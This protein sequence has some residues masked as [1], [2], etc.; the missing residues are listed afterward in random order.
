M[1]RLLLPI[2]I[3][4]ASACTGSGYV[5]YDSPGYASAD[6]R[7]VEVQPG[8]YAIADYSEPVF[9]VDNFYWRWYGGRWY[10]STYYTGGWAY[11]NPPTVIATIREPHRYAHYRPTGRDRVVIRDHRTGRFI[12]R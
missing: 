11:A 3:A 1:R 12:R 9:Y 2:I 5:A 6:V 7:Y 4:L 8:V 10:R